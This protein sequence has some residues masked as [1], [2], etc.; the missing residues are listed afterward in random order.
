[1]RYSNAPDRIEQPM[2][3]VQAQLLRNLA[4]EAYQP[5]EFQKDLSRIEAEKR[6]EALRS[7]IKLADSF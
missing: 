2:T 4:E 1:M 6:I 7:E 5:N 3:A